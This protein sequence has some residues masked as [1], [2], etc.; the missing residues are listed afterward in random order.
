MASWFRSHRDKF[1]LNYW[2]R[3]LLCHSLGGALLALAACSWGSHTVSS[4]HDTF[5]TTLQTG[6]LGAFGGG[7]LSA[8]VLQQP[9]RAGVALFEV[10]IQTSSFAT[11]DLTAHRYTVFCLIVACPCLADVASA[12]DATQDNVVGTVWTLC[13]WGIMYSPGDVVNSVHSL[14]PVRML[15]RVRLCPCSTVKT[16]CVGRASCCITHVCIAL[17]T[18]PK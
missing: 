1:L 12:Y 18:R 16:H 11:S 4:V 10:N 6:F 14:L 2:V 9:Q 3:L 15:T 5:T 13:W 17:W 8:L 7:I